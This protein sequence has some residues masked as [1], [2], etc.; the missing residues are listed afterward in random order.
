MGYDVHITRAA[1]W[2]DA[3][4]TP[5]P[6]PEWLK[7]VEDDPEMRL[8]GV[9]VAR[10]NKRPGLATASPGIAVWT[11]YSGHDETGN[12]A[13]FTWRKGCVTVKNPDD[14]ILAKMKA[15]AAL[16]DALVTGDDGEQY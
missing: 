12:M 10:I 15:I 14:K 2:L 11:A 7:Y 1:N 8:D 9:A 4:A 6:L 16:L 3:E 13:W 5:I